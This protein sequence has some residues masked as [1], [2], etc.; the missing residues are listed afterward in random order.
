[1]RGLKFILFGF[2]FILIGG[3]ILVDPQSSVGGFG[4]L[5]L[6]IVGIAFGIKGLNENN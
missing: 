1:M 5:I 2:M 4:E 6:F 3:F